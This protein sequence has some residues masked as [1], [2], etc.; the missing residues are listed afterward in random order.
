MRWRRTTAKVTPKKNSNSNKRRKNTMFQSSSSLV[1]RI[2]VASSV[3]G[4]STP[5]KT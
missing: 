2:P 3:K 5:L 4:A 1:R